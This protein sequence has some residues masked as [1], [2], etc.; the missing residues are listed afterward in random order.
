MNIYKLK[1]KTKYNNK[2]Y[3][4]RIIFKNINRC[5]IGEANVTNVKYNYSSD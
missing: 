5:L 4:E 3:F 1:E 2:H